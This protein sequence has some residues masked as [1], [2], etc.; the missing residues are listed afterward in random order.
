MLEYQSKNILEIFYNFLNNEDNASFKECSKY[1]NR[2]IGSKYFSNK[3]FDSYTIKKKDRWIFRQ[4]IHKYKLTINILRISTVYDLAYFNTYNPSSIRFHPWFDNDYYEYLLPNIKKLHLPDA[5]KKLINKNNFPSSITELKL[6]YAFNDP[7]KENYFPA[8]LLKLEFGRMYD[9][10]ILPNVLPE[11]LK[12]LIFSN[13]FD[14]PVKSG[15]LKRRSLKFT[16]LNAKFNKP[17][18]DHVLSSSLE[19]LQLSE[20]FNHQLPTL[21]PTLTTLILGDVFNQPIL[22]LPPELKLL[23]IGHEFKQSLP[24]LPLKLEKL[25]LNYDFYQSFRYVKL[26][27]TLKV[28]MIS[29]K[30]TFVKEE[31]EYLL[32]LPIKEIYTIDNRD[33]RSCLKNSSNI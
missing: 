1:L 31:I 17:I 20:S 14:K 29:S 9:E 6:G 24:E 4:M 12:E 13:H 19:V 28:L 15:D 32:A 22:K 11:S 26:P 3:Y 2:I 7:I 10:P 5:I 8:T 27:Q 33:I 30:Y 18:N 16:Q 25:F 21:P 23:A